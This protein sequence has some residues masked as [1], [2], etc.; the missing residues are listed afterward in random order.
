MRPASLPEGPFEDAANVI[1]AAECAASFRTLIRSGRVSE[2]TDP[3]GQ[4]A[5]YV[6]EQYSA[7]DYLRALSIRENLQKR[8]EALFDT[9]DVLVAAAQPIS[10]TPLDA[11]L[12]TDLAFPDPLGAIGNLCGLP[13]LSVPCGFTESNLPVG[14]QFV[15]RAGDDI[16]VIQAARTFQLHTEWHRKHPKIV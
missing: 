15:G 3:T 12:E 2:L 13:A 16:A 11:N 8:V 9:F 4:I 7:A 6:N 5:G 1:I 14:L 10:A